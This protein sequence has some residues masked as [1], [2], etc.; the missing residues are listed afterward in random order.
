MVILVSDGCEICDFDFCVIGSV[1]EWVGID[2]I[3]YVIGFD[4]VEQ[5]DQE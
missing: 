3:V 5:V 1:F 4:V 2:F